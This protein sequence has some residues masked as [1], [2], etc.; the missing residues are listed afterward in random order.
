MQ[1][2]KAPEIELQEPTSHVETDVSALVR[3][4]I[5]IQRVW[6]RYIVR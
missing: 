1:K 3:A 4:A 5:K 2:T 6:R